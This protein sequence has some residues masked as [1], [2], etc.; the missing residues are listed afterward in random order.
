MFISNTLFVP[1]SGDMV[2]PWFE[3]GDLSMAK[4]EGTN[5]NDISGERFGR[6]LVK[7]FSHKVEKNKYWFCVCDCGREKVVNYSNLKSGASSSCGCLHKERSSAASKTHG[8]SKHTVYKSWQHAKNRCTNENDLNWMSY[9]GR[10]IVMDTEWLNSFEAFWRDMGDS[11]EEGLTLER[12]DV[13]S[14]YCKDNCRWATQA[15]QMR[16]TRRSIHVETPWGRMCLADAADRL[17]I[18]RVTMQ[19]R[20]HK[21]LQGNALLYQ[22]QHHKSHTET[23]Q[24]PSLTSLADLGLDDNESTT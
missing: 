7:G 3:S 1:Q 12:K 10:G 15:E 23:E 11:F 5:I 19:M 4:I 20:W 2:F 21:G 17:G 6:W 8:L 9:G 13:D 24:E 16:N 18:P 14:N 22:G